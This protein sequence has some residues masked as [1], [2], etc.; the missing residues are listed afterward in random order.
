MKCSNT[1]PTYLVRFCKQPFLWRI[2]PSKTSKK[3]V[4]IASVEIE[5]GS[6]GRAGKENFKRVRIAWVEIAGDKNFDTP[7]LKV[8]VPIH[9]LNLVTSF[10]ISTKLWTWFI[11]WVKIFEV[12]HL[13]KVRT[14]L[15]MLQNIDSIRHV[16]QSIWHKMKDYSLQNFNYK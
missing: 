7:E 12:G 14:E 2:N 8:P 10:I 5:K 16:K 11:D 9:P 6:D 1:F 4:L 3:R 15:E 13:Q